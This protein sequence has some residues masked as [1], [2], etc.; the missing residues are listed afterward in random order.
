MFFLLGTFVPISFCL[1]LVW[2]RMT[3][4]CHEQSL[5]NAVLLA[6]CQNT[7]QCPAAFYLP[8]EWTPIVSSVGMPKKAAPHWSGLNIGHNL[9][10]D[11]QQLRHDVD[12]VSEHGKCI[13]V[14][15]IF[16]EVVEYRLWRQ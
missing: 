2:L 9:T 5:N 1:L 7:A 8:F 16:W 14:A 11:I 4:Y 10:G 3:Y 6:V 13:V 12:I 15:G